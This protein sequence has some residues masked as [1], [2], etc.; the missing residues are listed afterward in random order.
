M[1]DFLNQR[2]KDIKPSGIRRF[3]EIANE[4]EDVISLGVG[5]PD[6]ET[7]YNVRDAAADAL[8]KGQTYYTANAGLLE[9]RQLIAER[10]EDRYNLSYDAKSEILVTVGGSEAID[11]A[12]RAT[13]NPGDEVIYL[14]PAYVS[15]LPCIQLSGGIPVAIS[16]QEKHNFRLTAPELEA[17][18]TDKTKVLMLNYPNNPTG[19][20][21]EQA[22]IEALAEVIIKHDL[23]VITDEIYEDLTYSDSPHVTITAL[24]GM[25]ERTIYING[26]SKT[27]A[28]TGWR[29][30]YCC[31]PQALM[32]EIIKIH[33]FVIMAAPTLSQFAAVEALKN[34]NKAVQ[35]MRESYN[36]RR[37]FLLSELTRLGFTCFE[38]LGAF[39]VFPNI[40]PFGMSSDE[41]AMDL[42]KEERL[43]VV[44][45]TAFGASGEGFIRISYAYSIKELQD[46]I[47]R[48]ERYV[49]K[50][51]AKK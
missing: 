26:F 24:P 5:E 15:Y 50:K 47:I 4:M 41:F 6:F 14:E 27:Y 23:L 7:P 45:G 38:P 16:L 32:E 35:E 29:L 22:D 1:R 9:L 44:P 51:R 46:A 39:Y 13:I 42:I 17:A 34:S 30:G 10:L 33:Q 20:I 28:M 11:L 18:I 8:Y 36:Q 25:Q 2:V 21:L 48:L 31:G 49:D 12:L 37:R 19:A 40:S 3:F 43:A